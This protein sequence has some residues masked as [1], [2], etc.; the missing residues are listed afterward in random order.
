[1][2]IKYM[3]LVSFAIAAVSCHKTTP[4]KPA[5]PPD[6][7]KV[8]LKDMNERNLPSPYY[9]FE[10]ND[11]GDISLASF[12]S[13]LGVYEVIY[14]GKRILRMENTNLPNRDI[15]Q[16]EYVDSELV[17]INITHK[18]GVKYR[19]AFFGYTPTHQ[20]ETVDW[21]IKID[22]AGFTQELTLQLSY[23]PDGNL[24]ELVHHFYKV[25]P[26]TEVTYSDNFENYDSKLNVDA[27]SLLHP[28]QNH[29]LYLLPESKIQRNNPLREVRTGDGVNYEIDYTYTY[30]A[31]GRPTV[32]SGN[33]LWTKGPD[34]G[35]HFQ[36]QSTFSYYD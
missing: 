17:A 14:A 28:N 7:V 29:H 24:K 2:N 33:L 26:Q 16:Y 32:K 13:G 6:I 22:E 4:S 3:L 18:D 34:T 8:R 31:A 23:Y 36:T 12:S 20:L 27:F 35:K 19:R 15:L 10:Y 21:E 1:M 5:G 30:D 11:S 25:G 9:H